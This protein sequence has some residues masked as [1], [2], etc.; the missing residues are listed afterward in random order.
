MVLKVLAL[1]FF[2]LPAL[3]KDC[4]PLLHPSNL[5]QHA[6]AF[7]QIKS[8]EQF[9]PAFELAFEEAFNRLAKLNNSKSNPTYQNTIEALD[10][11]VAPLGQV[12]RIYGLYK[13]VN[14][15]ETL[16]KLDQKLVELYSFMREKLYFNKRI[17]M[18]IEK[19]YLAK[20]NLKLSHLQSEKLRRTYEEFI[21][22]GINL[23]K[24]KQERISTINT[25]LG[26]LTQQFSDNVLDSSN[27][28]HLSVSNADELNGLPDSDLQRA[29]NL[30]TQNGHPEAWDFNLTQSS[31]PAILKFA[32]D[33]RLREKVWK[34][35]MSLAT[36]GTND[37]QMLVVQIAKLR[38][39]KAKLFGFQ[40]YAHMTI[41]DRMAENPEE[42]KNFL[43]RLAEKVMPAAK[44]ELAELEHFAGSELKPWDESYYSIKLK[45]AQYDFNAE[46]LK[47]YLSFNQV[48]GAAFLIANKL[49][50]IKYVL[51][52]DLPVW[53]PEVKAY[54][55][56][57]RDGN[58]LALFY[59]DPFPR[60]TK[61]GGAG[62]INLVSPG[63]FAGKMQRPHVLN[64][65]NLTPATEGQPHLVS[66][67][68][69]TTIF[70]EL[71]HANHSILTQV[72]DPDLAGINVA[73]DFVELPSKLNE[74][75]AF[76]PEVL[77]LYA[78]HYQT[79]EVIPEAL[80]KK[81]KKSENFQTAIGL[82]G[83]I[84][85]SIL[86]LAWHSDQNFD[87][88]K[89][90]EDVIDFEN[91]TLEAFFA[92]RNFRVSEFSKLTRS[93]SFS[94]IFAGGYAAGY[95]SYLWGELYEK[96]IF[97]VFKRE[98]IFNPKVAAR[99]R[100]LLESGGSIPPKTLFK[101]FKGG[102]LDPDAL[103]KSLGIAL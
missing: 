16:K 71:G 41:Q 6:I 3:A 68:N 67:A 87:L 20:N 85:Y 2:S 10:L 58:H 25:E 76:D 78:H 36:E 45:K 55:V 4:N 64:V 103:L 66:A 79:G 43:V 98:G 82:L 100:K 30:A 21:E 31:Y 22:N 33:E 14:Q 57:D 75:W 32:T 84:R 99:L 96:D 95:Y 56:L 13:I 91:K 72:E 94:H 9:E 54:D 42:V 40:S 81:M 90:P 17:F 89:T 62:M 11:V 70:H 69:V 39:E 8:T 50:G 97:S 1:V 12:S 93:A 65:A 74:E 34:A 18:R 49:F 63:V 26:G 5:Y 51:R 88:I 60:Q 23:P 52:P 101:E 28:Y 19:L 86:D 48:Q 15:D 83:Q 37:N 35:S 80:V 73:H 27:S 7:N 46:A 92:H 53:H 77:K 61:R 38:Q 102:E 44:K 47:P 59:A 29:K 24:E